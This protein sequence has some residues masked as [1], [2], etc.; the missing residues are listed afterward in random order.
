MGGIETFLM[1]Q[2]RKIDRT[3]IQF[4]FLV[5]RAERGFF[6]DEILKIN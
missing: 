1:S 4:Y 5:H 3:K 6:E 2:Y